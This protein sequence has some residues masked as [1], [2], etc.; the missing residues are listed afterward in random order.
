MSGTWKGVDKPGGAHYYTPPSYAHLPDCPRCKYGTLI[1]SSDKTV[2]CID[3]HRE[4]TLDELRKPR[5]FPKKQA[6][7]HPPGAVEAERKA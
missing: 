7:P 2:K 1:A 5:V 4:Y 3:C 6:L